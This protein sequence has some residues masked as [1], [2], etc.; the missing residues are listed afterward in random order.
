MSSRCVSYG[1][2]GTHLRQYVD[3]LIAASE[4]QVEY[5]AAFVG[6]RRGL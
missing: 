1:S 6:H 5:R 4:G 3:P 2:D